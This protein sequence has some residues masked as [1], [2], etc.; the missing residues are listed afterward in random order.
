MP[1]DDDHDDR[2]AF[3]P[4]LPP[5]DRL[6]RHPS[7]MAAGGTGERI[8]LVTRPSRGRV[9]AA[10]AAGLAL[11]AV[12]T[13]GVLVGTGTL[14][15]P[16]DGPAVERVLAA[17]PRPEASTL[18]IA[19][20]SL[21]AVVR[22]EATGA[23]GMTTGT[24][25]IVRDDGYLLT[26]AAPLDG[27]EAVTVVLD[28]GTRAPAVVV[29][30]DWASDVAVLSVDQTGL[31]VATMSEDPDLDFGDATVVVD[32]A[33]PGGPAPALIEGFVADADRRIDRDDGSSL[34]G[35]VEVRTRAAGTASRGAT[36]GILL[37][38]QGAVVGILSG[39]VPGGAEDETSLTPRYA[40][41][42]DHARRVFDAI[43]ATGGYDTPFLGTTGHDVDER[44]AERAGVSAGVVV[45][46]VQGPALDAGLAPD[47]VIIAVD[48]EPVTS[49]NDLVVALR[50]HQP[51]QTLALTYVRRG[52]EA[53]ALATLMA[54][55]GLP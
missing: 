8:E 47:D 18:A 26:S 44:E 32:A 43:L 28:D 45:D 41:P 3:E 15:E 49:L 27:T 54:K 33:P 4:P 53:V 35:M 21:P 11:G 29:G 22:M 9:V 24:A 23:S 14:D 10:A 37:D 39:Q 12:A 5:E 34:F 38:D 46:A 17:A 52:S 51:G 13:V 31:P 16:T 48:G 30:R 42:V 55:P 36:G 6:W 40:V 25:V 50:E 1:T 20:Q 7:E 19:E 2:D